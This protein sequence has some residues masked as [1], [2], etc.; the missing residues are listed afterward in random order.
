[1]RAFYE[2][3]LDG[4]F[5]ATGSTRG[6]WASD[7]QHGSPPIALM[8]RA[9]ERLVPH[10]GPLRWTVDLARPL[11]LG[12]VEVRAA[13]LRTGRRTALVGAEVVAAGRTCY[14]AR[15]LMV[16]P[17][18]DAPEATPG[19]PEAREGVAFQFPFFPWDEGFHTAIEAR[20]IAGEPGTGDLRVWMRPLVALVE[21]EEA[22]PM[23]RVAALTDAGSGVGWG[24]DTRIWTFLNADL[25]QHVLRPPRGPWVGLHA[26]T[27]RA[28]DGVGLARTEVFDADGVIGDVQQGLVLARAASAAG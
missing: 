4:S 2:P 7:Q 23:Q 24:L 17:V 19:Q 25:D 12:R 15:I 9:A 11:P 18:A 14:T 6:P 28:A 5:A 26:R 10:A 8:V 13:C 20:R 27:R 1:M 21:G 22:T 16:V 3:L